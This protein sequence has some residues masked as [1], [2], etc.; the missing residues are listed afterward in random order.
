MGNIKNSV[1]SLKLKMK[2][3]IVS[4]NDT[5]AFNSFQNYIEEY[6][7]QDRSGAIKTFLPVDFVMFKDLFNLFINRDNFKGLGVLLNYAEQR[8]LKIT[9]LDLSVFKPSMEYYLNHN[10]KL[11]N[12]LVFMKYYVYRQECLFKE[13]NLTPESLRKM[14][15]SEINEYSNILFPHNN[16]A[17]LKDLFSYLVKRLTLRDTSKL[18]SNEIIGSNRVVDNH[19]KQDLMQKFINYFTKYTVPFMDSPHVVNNFIR[20]NDVADYSAGKFEE[21][22]SF[23][24]VM[25]LSLSYGERNVFQEFIL[26]HLK[27]YKNRNFGHL[28][29]SYSK[30]NIK[31]YT[32]NLNKRIKNREIT[33]P[34]DKTNE[35][36]LSLMQH[37][38]MIEEMKE[39]SGPLKN[40]YISEVICSL[41]SDGSVD[42]YS[43]QVQKLFK[44]K[45]AKESD[46]YTACMMKALLKEGDISSAMRVLDEGEKSQ[47]GRKQAIENYYVNIYDHC[48]GEKESKERH[49]EFFPDILK[50]R[51]LR[52]KKDLER[53]GRVSQYQKKLV[54]E[55]YSKVNLQE[56]IPVSYTDFKERHYNMMKTLKNNS[57]QMMLMKMVKSAI[58]DSD[59]K[60]INQLFTYLMVNKEEE[61][62]RRGV[63]NKIEAYSKLHKPSQ[64]LS[65][66]KEAND[67]LRVL[68]TYVKKPYDDL[69]TL[70][71]PLT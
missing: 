41:E 18:N 19:T 65:S 6:N 48:F 44:S 2:Y 12:L 63:R 8:R 62:L 24:S 27:K 52:M 16:L 42:F 64:K 35:I 38:K 14:S 31:K 7:T 51:S 68:F 26:D 58:K 60:N 28:P 10:F 9:N 36:L 1:Q 37:H 43:R 50:E 40:H 39:L 34:S 25:E 53:A 54:A 49:V 56:N 13:F 57:Q 30:K 47:V 20:E 61:D 32:Q 66:L 4:N 46:L 15:A 11:S 71:S 17:D 3:G 70:V 23:E 55:K 69:N 21:P 67:P 29:S 59:Y 22:N 45:A 33:Q 5:L